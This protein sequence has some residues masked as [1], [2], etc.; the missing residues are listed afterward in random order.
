MNKFSGKYL[1]NLRSQIIH[2]DSKSV[3]KT[4][5]PKDNRGKGEQFSPTD[6]LAA[7]LGSCMVTIMAIRAM[8]KGI[9]LAKIDFEIEKV[10]QANPRRVGEIQLKLKLPASLTMSERA[11]LEEEGLKCPVALSLHPDL[12]QKVTFIYD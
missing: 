2:L 5:A 7:A 10:M 3:L 11:Y 1:G 6:L 8:D 12:N 4:D 9:Q